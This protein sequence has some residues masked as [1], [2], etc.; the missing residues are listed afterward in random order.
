MLTDKQTKNTFI[1]TIII[2]IIFI[3]VSSLIISFIELNKKRKS[4][5]AHIYA[6]MKYYT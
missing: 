3:F 2:I 1:R 4:I 6:K 5:Y